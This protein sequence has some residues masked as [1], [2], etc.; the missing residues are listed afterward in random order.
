[1]RRRSGGG[2]RGPGLLGTAARTAVITGTASTVAGRVGA[3]QETA[4]RREHQAA[5]D[6][7]QLQDRQLQARI[8]AQVAEAVG[9]AP[10]TEAVATSV[11]DLHGRLMKLGE[12]REAGLLTDDEFAQQKARFLG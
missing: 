1:M 8:D 7:H 3:G 9:R 11:D 10:V 4:L 6:R 5:A 12:L 2:R